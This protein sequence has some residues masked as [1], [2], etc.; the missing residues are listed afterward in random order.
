MCIVINR[1]TKSSITLSNRVKRILK[2][3]KADFDSYETVS[4]SKLSRDESL[5]RDFY[6]KVIKSNQLN[7]ID[8][9]FLYQLSQRKII[10]APLVNYISEVALQNPKK[11]SATNAMT[12]IAEEALEV[13][14]FLCNHFEFH[15]N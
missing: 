14:R 13:Q 4:K 10:N 7:I 8:V 12:T 1:K 15:P 6:K 3:W 2:E 5:E 11:E 9:H